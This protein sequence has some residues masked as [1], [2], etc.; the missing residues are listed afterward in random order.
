M[1]AGD[2]GLVSTNEQTG[3][4]VTFSSSS[5]G[6]PGGSCDSSFGSGIGVFTSAR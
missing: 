4:S 5:P 1:G 2:Q 6:D 3:C